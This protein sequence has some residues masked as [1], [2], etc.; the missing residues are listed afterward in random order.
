MRAGMPKEHDRAGLSHERVTKTESRTTRCE[1]YRSQPVSITLHCTLAHDL[2]NDLAIILGECDLLEDGVNQKFPRATRLANIRTTARRMANRLATRPCP[3][4]NGGLP[5]P[6][7]ARNECTDLANL[8]GGTP[9]ATV[10]S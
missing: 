5:Q 8:D 1:N 6:A 2:N 4:D 3:V 9:G 10:G 7:Q